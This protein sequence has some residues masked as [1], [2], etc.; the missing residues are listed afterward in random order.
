MANEIYLKRD[1]WDGTKWLRGFKKRWSH[2]VTTRKSKR[3]TK[4][5]S[6]TDLREYIQ[7]FVAQYKEMLASLNLIPDF[8]VDIDET[9]AEPAGLTSPPELFGTRGKSEHHIQSLIKDDCRT[10]VVCAAASGK[11]WMTVKIY[12][13]RSS[14]T[15]SNKARLPVKDQ[16]RILR[17]DWPTFYARHRKGTMTL[18]LW[19]K[20][21]RQL[22]DEMD[23]TRGDRPALILCDHPKVHHDIE[24]MREMLQR[25]V[26]FL[27]FP[28]N[29]SHLIQP[30]DGAPFAVYKQQARIFRYRLSTA[31]ALSQSDLLE[32]VTYED[33]AKHLAFATEVIKAGFRDRGIWPFDESRILAILE[34]NVPLPDSNGSGSIPEEAI[35]FKTQI[36][37]ELTGTSRVKVTRVRGLEEEDQLYAGHLLIELE[38]RKNAELARQRAEKERE[39]EEVAR[40]KK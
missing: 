8:I 28:H 3:S 36:L 39:K 21:V 6:N 9:K 34:K 38:D 4:E 11:T 20:V 32:E 1:Y 17:G 25:D 12:Q 31:S 35:L 2:I 27:F 18:D 5:R 10:L 40:K 24:L 14:A 7:K 29:T 19:R 23:L 16:T 26:H 37:K 30:L 33:N 22:V 15:L 13:A